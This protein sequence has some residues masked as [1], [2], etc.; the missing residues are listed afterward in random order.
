MM[1][2][3]VC[4]LMEMTGRPFVRNKRAHL[5]HLMAHFRRSQCALLTHPTS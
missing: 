4:T 1:L 2:L 5:P 3:L